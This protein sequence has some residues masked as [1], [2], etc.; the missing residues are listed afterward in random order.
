[1]DRIH[2]LRQNPQEAAEFF[3]KKLAFTLGPVELGSMLEDGKV[4]LIDVRHKEDYEESHIEKSVNIEKEDLESKFSELSKD[5]VYVISCY[6]QQ[7]HLG[8][9]AA[10]KMAVN[11]YK[12]MELEGGFKAWKED[13]R[14]PT[15]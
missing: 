7:C 8:A 1:M 9:G 11:G 3:A 4:K 5:N 6:S 13:Y 15:T 12:V 14:F 10:H 2:E